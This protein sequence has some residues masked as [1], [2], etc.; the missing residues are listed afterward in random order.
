MPD[1]SLRRS[2]VLGSVYLLIGLHI[3]HWK[4][5]GCS[6]APLELN[7]V[8]YTLHLGMITAGFIFMSAAV[9]ST[10]IVG[11]FFCSWG[12]H[13]L[14]LQD[15]SSWLLSKAGIRPKPVRSRM[16]LW[17]PILAMFNLFIFPLAK[18]LWE[19][20]G[21]PDFHVVSDVHQWSS[22]ISNNLWR[23]LPGPGITVLT[24]V[25]CGFLMIYFLGSRSFC[26]YA[27]PYGAIFS[28]VDRLAPG[29][30]ALTGDCTQC[31]LCTARCQSDIRV[32]EEINR[33]GMVVNPACLKDL[34]CVS[35]CNEQAIHFSFTSPPLFGKD[36]QVKKYYSYS[37]FED[38]VIGIIF[39][40]SLFILRGLY[41]TIPFL[42]AIAIS[43]LFASYFLFAYRLI[44]EK[45]ICLFN[46]NTLKKM[47]RYT[48][49]GK[50]SLIIGLFILS[51]ML[52]SIFIRWHYYSGT[53]AYL[54]VKK[55]AEVSAGGYMSPHLFK[56]ADL[57]LVHFKKID[58]W[59]LL[60]PA[61]INR[62][63]ASLY[64]MQR[65]YP[66]AVQHL[67]K[68]L[69]QS[70]ADNEARL[71]LG[72]AYH[73]WGKSAEASDVFR[74]LISGFGQLFSKRDTAIFAG[75]NSQLGDILVSQKKYRSAFLC[76]SAA[77]SM[78]S[79]NAVLWL[80]YG[81]ALV[82]NGQ[83]SRA[84]DCLIKS[85]EIDPGCAPAHFNLGTV[86]ALMS[87]TEDAVLHYRL[88]AQL[89]PKRAETFCNLGILFFKQHKFNEAEVALGKAGEL[90]PNSAIIYSYMAKVLDEK[91]ESHRSDNIIQ[92]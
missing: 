44:K 29:R 20:N 16:L 40:L 23:N 83:L 7:E 35:V 88:S 31:G 14:A 58:R 43:I 78:D 27:C 51:F 86:Y 65:D 49:V 55:Y 50:F 30:I 75:A 21:L 82:K 1:Y 39:L 67:Q 37:R 42:L 19:G 81:S 6:L 18:R 56:T 33:F 70:P 57:A 38:F 3:A 17:I 90:D 71:R 36:T 73:L 47:G 24:F 25:V 89:N 85:L 69:L 76:Y 62:Q 72:N 87:Q 22:F 45:G 4:I 63:L 5:S 10:L 64:L 26:N 8:S 15:L 13:L 74:N 68:T 32:H 59:G 48:S 66:L 84:K 11:R 9:I 92:Q 54:L 77:L 80:S 41:E 53:R 12:C 79:C 52:H 61:S 28:V 46:N 2:I 60:T 91:K 34:D